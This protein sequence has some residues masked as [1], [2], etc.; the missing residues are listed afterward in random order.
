MPAPKPKP[1]V[2][3]A[4]KPDVKADPSPP[5]KVKAGKESKFP[6][7]ITAATDVGLDPLTTSSFTGKKKK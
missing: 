7:A 2:K 4:A 5:V 1:A 6:V 3:A